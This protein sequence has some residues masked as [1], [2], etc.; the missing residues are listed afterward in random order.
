MTDLKEENIMIG[1]SN[2]TENS[3]NENILYLEDPF[4]KTIPVMDPEN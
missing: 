4:F 2:V 3:S 1:E